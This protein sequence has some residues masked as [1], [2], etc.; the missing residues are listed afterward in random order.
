MEIYLNR[1]QHSFYVEQLPLEVLSIIDHLATSSDSTSTKNSIELLELY[2]RL[3]VPMQKKVTRILNLGVAFEANKCTCTFNSTFYPSRLYALFNSFTRISDVY[4]F[5]YAITKNTKMI[6]LNDHA[7]TS[8][9][10]AYDFQHMPDTSFKLMKN[11]MVFLPLPFFDF[12]NQVVDSVTQPTANK[13][14]EAFIQNDAK[15]FSATYFLQSN[16]FKNKAPIIY[17]Y[18]EFIGE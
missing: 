4:T 10:T 2:A 14:Q 3:T 18:A 8:V 17:K 15:K 11:V 9:I 13:L 12:I 6:N 5:C 1:E 7:Y 16:T